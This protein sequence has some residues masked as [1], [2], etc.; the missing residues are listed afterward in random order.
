[1][2]PIKK[3]AMIGA[4]GMLGIP[5]AVALMEAGFEV[6]ALARS[7][8]S[9]RRSLPAG[10]AIVQ[11]DVRDEESLRRGLHGQDGVYLSLSVAPGQREGDFHTEVQGLEHILAAAREANVAR[12]AYLSAMIHDTPPSNTWW[13]LDVW[14]HAL[15]RIKS[16]GIPYTIFYPTNFMETL[17][18]RHSAGRLFVMLGR[19]RHPNYWIAGSDFGR[20][21]A[22]SFALPQAANREY[23]IQGPE[24][25]TYDGAAVRFASALRRSPFVVRVPIWMARIGGVFSNSLN[26]NANIMHAVLSYPEQFKAADTWQD[27]GRPETTI[28]QFAL[29]QAKT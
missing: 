12:I 29:R 13:V 17:A 9:A 6:T 5:V 2:R 23:Y 22:R 10:I 7:P 28:E 11:A 19:A 16:S 20:Q 14:R 15:A 21:V 8:E 18:Q 25:L 3:I 27:L 4:T 1:M 24:P 26:F